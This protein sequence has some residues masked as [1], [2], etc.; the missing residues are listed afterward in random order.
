ML[1]VALKLSIPLTP[2][3]Q[4][5]CVLSAVGLKMQV[6]KIVNLQKICQQLI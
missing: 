4:H 5:N 2:L 6:V 3:Q 1:I